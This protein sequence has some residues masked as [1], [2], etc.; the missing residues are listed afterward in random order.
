VKRTALVLAL[1]ATLG[2]YVADL[3]LLG[4]PAFRNGWWTLPLFLVPFVLLLA[5]RGAENSG[6]LAAGAWI[7]FGAALAAYPALRLFVGIYPEA[8]E[9]KAGMRAPNFTLKDQEGRDA[10]LSDFTDDH[11]VLLVF[12]RSRG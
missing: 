9:L 7:L 3:L 5:G 4:V 12:I 11:R 8:V 1:L 6:K 10:S 2:V